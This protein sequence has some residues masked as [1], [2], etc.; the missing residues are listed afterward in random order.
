[1]PCTL[2]Y[3]H[4]DDDVPTFWLLLFLRPSN[5]CP[6]LHRPTDCHPR[7]LATIWPRLQHGHPVRPLL[8][9]RLLKSAES[10]QP[11]QWEGRGFGELTACLFEAQGLPPKWLLWSSP[12]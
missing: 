9:G 4:Q 7:G 8:R 5:S 2:P 12:K 6:R 3:G 1:M 11:E 10:P